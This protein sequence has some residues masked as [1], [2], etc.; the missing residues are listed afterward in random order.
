MVRIVNGVIVH[1]DDRPRINQPVLDK[2]KKILPN[3][4]G[5]LGSL[6]ESFSFMGYKIEIVWVLVLF[7]MGFMYGPGVMVAA[8]GILWVY[9][10][11]LD[12]VYKKQ[13]KINSFR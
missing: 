10:R 2:N 8:A 9:Q 7:L 3:T 6:S 1:D 13:E 5:K 12:V 4:Y 11:N